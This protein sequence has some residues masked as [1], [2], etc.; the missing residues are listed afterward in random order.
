MN[1]LS[2][3]SLKT[4]LLAGVLAFGAGS[5]AG[6]YCGYQY[7]SGQVSK[8]KADHLADA[9][10]EQDRL[11]G[12]AQDIGQALGKEAQARAGER[13]TWERR[14]KD[15]KNRLVNCGNGL[16]PPADSVRLTGE[17]VSLWNSALYR[18]AKPPTDSP[19]VDDAAGSAG[20]APADSLENLSE[21]AERWAKCRATLSAWQNF[22][23]RAG[24]VK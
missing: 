21:N 14:L 2:L 4:T 8:E 12:I 7:H 13:V 1:L 15:A 16:S 3:V 9:I 5:I 23:R 10:K 20:A 19:R 18:G 6:I 24:W 17:Y 11:K 22:A